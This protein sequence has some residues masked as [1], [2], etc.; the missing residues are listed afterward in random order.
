MTQDFTLVIPPG[1]AI[2]DGDTVTISDGVNSVVFEF[3]DT[4]PFTGTKVQFVG[5]P[6]V[7]VAQNLRNAINNHPT[8]NVTARTTPTSDKVELIGAAHAEVAGIQK[9][10][11]VT[12]AGGSFATTSETAGLA[13]LLGVVTRTGPLTGNLVVTLTSSDT[14]EA[15][16]PVTVTIPDGFATANFQLNAIDDTD[17]DGTQNVVITPSV[18]GYTSVTATVDVADNELP[19]QLSV[20]FVGGPISE[21]DPNVSPGA[22]MGTVTRTT[23]PLTDLVVQLFSL[24]TTEAVP[25]QTTVVIPA[26]FSSQ[27]FWVNAVDDIIVDGAQTVTIAAIAAGFRAGTT[28]LSV[29]DAGGDTAAPNT[30]VWTAEGPVRVTP[31]QAEGLP[32]G[33]PVIGA[34]NAVAVDPSDPNVIYIGSVNGG[35]WKTI[36]ATDATGPTW[37]PLTDNLP[38]NSISSLEFD[39]SDPSS[40]TL[41]AGIGRTSSLLLPSGASTGSQLTGLLRTTDGGATWSQLSPVNLLNRNVTAVSARGNVILAAA[42]DSNSGLFRSVDTGGTFTLIS[43]TGGLPLGP[44]SDLV[45]D[46][47]DPQRFY[48]GVLGAGVFRSADGGATWTNTNAPG[49]FTPATNNS[50]KIAVHSDPGGGTN[51]VYLAV[52]NSGQLTNLLRSPSLGAPG[53]WTAQAVGALQFTAPFGGAAGGLNLS[54]VA[55]PLN[56]NRVYVGED[57]QQ[58]NAGPA[59]PNDQFTGANANGARDFSGRLFRVE[60][61]SGQVNI[62]T[63]NQTLSNSAPHSHSRDMVFNPLGQIIEVNEGGIYLRTNPATNQGDWFSLNGNLQI[64][65]FTN[66][67]YDS[68]TRTIIAGAGDVGVLEQSAPGSLNWT[69]IGLAPGV[70]LVFTNDG[71]DVA[72][73]DTSIPGQSIRYSATQFLGNSVNSFRRRTFN[74]SGNLVP[75]SDRPV[76]LVVNGTG[77]QT[78]HQIDPRQFNTPVEL[79]A[80]N[81]SRMVI[82]GANAIYESFDQGDTLT[83]LGNGGG[84]VAMTYGGR[85][86]GMNNLAVLWAGVG[87]NVLLRTTAGGSLV[88]TPGYTAAGGGPVRDLTI[89]PDDWMTA[90]V[91]D[92]NNQVF[93]TSNAGATY[94]NITGSL[95]ALTGNYLSVL[96]VPGAGAAADR[97]LVGSRD[98]VFQALTS[99]PLVWTEYGAGLPNV[100]VA[101][102]DYDARAG[103]LVAGTQ[104]RGAFTTTALGEAGSLSVQILNSNPPDIFED[105]ADGTVRAR[106]TRTTA[107]GDLPVFLTSSNT[108]KATIPAS[109]TIPHGL[110]FV[111]VAIDLNNQDNEIADGTHTVIISASAAGFGSSAN[112]FDVVDDEIARL[113]LTINPAGVSEHAGKGAATATLTRNSSTDQPLLVSIIS[114][115]LSE[116]RAA[117]TVV[118]PAGLSSITFPIDAID[119]LVSDVMHAVQF[120]AAA[121]GHFSGVATLNVSDESNVVRHDLRGDDNVVRAQGHVLIQG[122]RITNSSTVGIRVDAAARTIPAQP[123]PGVARN[124]PVLNPTGWVPSVTLQNNVVAFSGT[125]GIQVSGDTT[126]AGQAPGVIPFARVINNTI[127]G[128]TTPS[129]IG[130]QVTDNASPTIL[131]NIVANLT[132]GVSVDASSQAAGT[133]LGGTLYQRAPTTLADTGAPN[134]GLGSFPILLAPNDLLFRNSAIGDFELVQGSLAIDSSINS[135]PERPELVA[136]Y[137]PLGIPPSD[138][139]APEYDITGRLRGDNPFVNSPPALGSNV[140][141]DRGAIER[142]DPVLASVDDLTVTET[143]GG[144]SAVVIV[145]LSEPVN[146]PLT[147]N[148]TTANGTALAGSDYTATSGSLSFSPGTTTLAVTV[149]IAGDLVDEFDETF[150]LNLSNLSAGALIGDSQGQITIVDDDSLV[151]VFIND[152]SQAEGDAGTTNFVFTV[153]LGAASG[154]QVRVEFATRDNTATLADGDYASSTGTLTF[155]PGQTAQLVTVQVTGNQFVEPNETF[156]VDLFNPLNATI[157]RITGVGTIVDDEPIISIS[158]IT[159]QE[160]STGTTSA[161]FTV[162]LNKPTLTED[163]VVSFNT[164]DGTATQ[165]G[166]YTSA[167]N[168]LTISAGETTGKITVQVV[169]DTLPESSE[170][171]DLVLSSPS[172]TAK[173]AADNIATATILDDEPRITISDAT[174]NPEGNTGTRD[175]VFTVLLSNSST[176]P[177]TVVFTT[178]DGTAVDENSPPRNDYLSTTGTL[179]FAPGETAKP[180]TVRVVG[181]TLNELNETF[182]VNLSSETS[183]LIVDGQGLGT[184]VD[185]DPQPFISI[186]NVALAEGHSGATNFVFDVELTAESGQ[187]I[188]VA[189]TTVGNSATSGVDFTPTGGTLTFAAGQTVQTI[190]VAVT[191]DTLGE[192]DETFFVDLSSSVNAQ[193]PVTP[194]RGTGTILD[195]EPRISIF[196]VTVTENNQAVFTVQL[197]HVGGADVSVAFNTGN[198]TAT[199]PAD[200]TATSGV[201]VFSFALNETLKT[202]TVPIVDDSLDEPDETFQVTLSA[203]TSAVIADGLAIGTIVDNDLAPTISLGDITVTEGQSGF[204]NAVFTATLSGASGRQITVAFATSDGTALAPGDYLASSG[205]ITFAPGQLMQ[206][207]TIQVQGD[208]VAETNENFQVTLSNPVNA[209]LADGLAVGTIVED[210]PLV[211]IDDQSIQESN[212]DLNAIFVLRLDRASSVNVTVTYATSDGSATAPADYTATS[213]TVTF[214]PNETVQLI[215]V[216]VKGDTLD[217]N[218]ETFLVSLTGATGA[219]IG[220]GVAVGTILDDDALPAL[221]ISDPAPVPEGNSGQTNA[222]FTV[223]L[224]P[225]SGRTLTVAFNTVN[226]TAIA[227]ADYTATSGTL[228]FAPGESTKQI[229]VRV[230]GDTLG[231]P[232]ETFFVNLTSL[233]GPTGTNAVYADA[234]GQGTILDDEPRISISSAT[235]PTE[236]DAGNANLVFTVSLSGTAS[237]PVS[238]AFTTADNTALGRTRLPEHQRHAVVRAGPDEQNVTVQVIGD[239]IDEINETFFVDL[240]N[241]STNAVIAASRGTGTIIDNDPLPLV[242]ILDSSVQEGDS[243]TTDMVF[244]VALGLGQRPHCDGRLL[245]RPRHR[246]GHGPISRPPAGRS[247]SLRAR[248]SSR[249]PCASWA[250]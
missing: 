41:I 107:V 161:V 56:A 117:L 62:L 34:I 198:V 203:A 10:V 209:T 80:I 20:S 225:V 187:Q 141:K 50:I 153:S 111:D 12:L 42:N 185:D 165:P 167:G 5:L 57:R 164:A 18:A 184:I 86:L 104:G 127:F 124:L 118:I 22:I 9:D 175:A 13:A 150:F 21:N 174:V 182:F 24:D 128:N 232:N 226:D 69:N 139:L 181:D 30:P 109:V 60:F 221:S 52:L 169:A 215:T 115:D 163:V 202:I 199:A 15:Q 46:P 47:S 204:T 74:S 27:S 173:L 1:A 48:V 66:V 200:Y 130:I 25:A 186:S 231:E 147:V 219:N 140:F 33:N 70:P 83:S 77:G 53:T 11:I 206:T 191:G 250:S 51:A 82:G 114:S 4:G 224:T 68:N 88:A 156:F 129:G 32:N 112:L 126:P 138:V 84:A 237:G 229:T 245:H 65:E 178:A 212:S 236:P 170:T 134:N 101:D 8:L 248:R 108:A 177:V 97:V 214:A 61:G 213:G 73:D 146:F 35:I 230:L 197:T 145:R 216:V 106:I 143:N 67:A 148:F 195:D 207:L 244:T 166:D 23:P 144:T 247:P 72:V 87:G 63:H 211:F 71:T 142:L 78:L 238:V 222:V 36:N 103:I 58:G 43:G 94:T 159:V 218:D 96:F 196:D 201:L 179:T 194:L 137:A 37:T 55:D 122:N 7:T 31:G 79:N 249:S 235:L 180:V 155:A 205:T 110:T 6:A 239:V 158:D 26:G 119:D 152:V 176:A 121:S 100:L 233:P 246:R 49:T 189:Y 172:N 210:E 220:D 227:G 40:Q 29:L 234:Q 135:V 241:P 162:T 228:T 217:E 95:T 208:T 188:T 89:D 3:D 91:I 17:P 102:M 92:A 85:R 59:V 154:K 45:G 14:T 120:T 19:P 243:G 28:T 98:G 76:A 38:S 123:H 54:L 193:L 39:P 151:Q 223:T 133:I 16:V 136:V 125:V 192:A 190:T 168:M 93:M 99:A 64:T 157:G 149:S 160:G 81:R 240:I 116:A 90:Y 105:A 75:G 171:F 2:S 113:T 183:S 242:S 44:V 131:N 132:T